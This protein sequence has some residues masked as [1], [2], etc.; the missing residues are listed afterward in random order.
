[1]YYK[2]ISRSFGEIENDTNG[3]LDR[4]KSTIAADLAQGAEGVGIHMLEELKQQNSQEYEEIQIQ[5]REEKELNATLE[6]QSQKYIQ[7]LKTQDSEIQKLKESIGR[8]DELLAEIKSKWFETTSRWNSEKEKLTT[9]NMKLSDE[10]KIAQR[11]STEL[12][13]ALHRQ[14][15]EHQEI[16]VQ[17]NICQKELEKALVLA[18]GFKEDM[19]Q[20]EEKNN[21]LL[22]QIRIEH[23]DRANEKASLEKLE[24]ENKK[25]IKDLEKLSL[26]L[27]DSEDKQ[28]RLEQEKIEL[29]KFLNTEREQ[30]NLD[31][32][33][34]KADL[35]DQ[36]K[37]NDEFL[38]DFYLK[39]L[40]AI[41]GEK[42]AALQNH[43][44]DW[45]KKLNEEKAAA[46]DNMKAE[47]RQQIEALRRQFAQ[48]EAQI[49]ASEAVHIASRREAEALKNKLERPQGTPECDQGFVHKQCSTTTTSDE[50]TLRPNS[51]L[52][53]NRQRLPPF[54]RKSTPSRMSSVTVQNDLHP[55]IPELQKRPRSASAAVSLSSRLVI[56]LLLQVGLTLCGF[57]LCVS[58]F[59]RLCGKS[60]LLSYNSSLCARKNRI[61]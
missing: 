5:L 12:S 25:L 21:L 24:N 13:H 51:I 60:T 58:H 22:D 47:H 33:R 9:E 50:E 43:V 41:V 39:Q 3:F 38:H 46:L 32:S 18:T 53:N 57:T 20:Q 10:L 1:M 15:L 49:K 55:Q 2:I 61:N 23:K 48:L 37:K 59:V 35:E 17:F 44:K 30:F 54:V 29:E 8:K 45:E 31:R 56:L 27:R 6:N 36:R 26:D 16:K 40:D 4:L 14:K 11:H 7:Q 28:D 42:V 19:D 34:L 52:N